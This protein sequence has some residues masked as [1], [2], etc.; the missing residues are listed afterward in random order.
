MTHTPALLCP[1]STVTCVTGS[2]D[3][4]NAGRLFAQTI[5]FEDSAELINYFD[6][7]YQRN[8]YIPDSTNTIECENTGTSP[9]GDATKDLSSDVSLMLNDAAVD[10]MSANQRPSKATLEVAED[11]SSDACASLPLSGHVEHAVRQYFAALDGE[12]SSNLYE[13]ILS[14]VEK[15][16]LTVVLEYTQGNQSKCAKILGLN[17]GTLRTKL[18]TYHLL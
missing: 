7:A 14:E 3:S 2:D 13:L 5:Y 6:I 16:L 12:A 17:R 8:T 4:S 15:P 9:N 11:N 18:K 10:L 1:S